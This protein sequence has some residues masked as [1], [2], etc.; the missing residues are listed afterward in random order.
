MVVRSA[1]DPN[2][3]LDPLVEFARWHKVDATAIDFR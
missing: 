3:K 2:R 1:S